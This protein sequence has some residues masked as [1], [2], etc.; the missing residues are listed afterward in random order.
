MPWQLFLDDERFPPL[1]GKN[2]MI[3][4]DSDEA[5][6]LIHEHGMPI[7]ISFDHDL[8]EDKLTGYDFTKLFVDLLLDGTYILHE[9]FDFYVHSQNPVGKVNIE[10]YIRSYYKVMH[11]TL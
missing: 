7:F 9:E 5:M 1:D 10:S 11:E 2:W 4:R 3:A 8:G 6:A